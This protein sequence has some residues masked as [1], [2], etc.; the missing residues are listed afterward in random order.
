MHLHSLT[1]QAIGPFAGRHHIDF[2]ELGASGLFLLEGPTGAGKSTV[3]DAVVFALYGKVAS[4]AAS[5]D[6]LRSAYAA[7]E[8]ESF[9]D[10]I[11]ETGAGVFRVRRTPAFQ[12]PKKKGTGTTTQQAGVGLWRLPA[13]PDSLTGS[14]DDA[15]DGDLLS[16]RLDEAGAELQRI[17]GLDRQQFVQTVVLPQ[18]EFASFLRANPEDRR[19]LLQKVFG[20]EIYERAQSELA[21]MQRE[22][23]KSTEGARAGVRQG[24][25]LFCSSAQMRANDAETLRTA[26][27]PDLPDLTAERVAVL[28]ADVLKREAEESEANAQQVA[29]RDALDT[30]KTLAEK[31]TTRTAL[32]AERDTLAAQHESVAADRAHLDAATRAGV[33]VPA[34]DGAQKAQDDVATAHEGL[35]LARAD[36]LVADTDRDDADL[37]G[38][39]DEIADASTRLHHLIPVENLV[40]ERESELSDGRSALQTMDAEIVTLRADSAQRPELRAEH[41][42]AVGK[43]GALAGELGLRQE[44]V[45]AAQAVQAAAKAVDSVGAELADAHSAGEAAATAAVAANDDAHALRASRIAGIAGELAGAL[46]QGEGCP[47][48]GGSDHPEPAQLTDDHPGADAVEEAQSAASAAQDALTSA[49]ATVDRLAERLEGHRVAAGGATAN[50]AAEH[51]AAAVASVDEARAAVEERDDARS[52]LVAFDE[53]TAAVSKRLGD[54]DRESA[55]ERSR[56]EALSASINA[57]TATIRTAIDAATPLLVE[58][59]PSGE[60]EEPTLEPLVD[61]LRERRDSIDALISARSTLSAAEH[62][63][64]AREA[65]VA[66]IVEK[67]GFSAL[68]EALEAALS[69]NER[70]RLDRAVRDHEAASS[71]VDA[72]LVALADLSDGV[73]ADVAGARAVMDEAD[74]SST[75]A[76][77]RVG[78]ATRQAE[79]ART[80]AATLTSAL[81]ALTSADV[82]AEPVLRMAGLASGTSGDNSKSMS[83]ATFVLVR[84]FE[85]VVN[86]ANDRL[87]TMSDGR[88]ELVRSEEREAVRTRKM[89]LAMKVV[90]HWTEQSRDPRTLSGGETFYVS[91]CLALGMADV[92]TAEAGGVDLGTLFVDEGFGTLDPEALEKVLDVLG[93]LRDGGR[94]IGVVSHVDAMKQSIAERI[95]VR[96]RQDGSSTLSVRAGS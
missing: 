78:L 92:V 14:D 7:P 67:S 96:R 3:I 30:Q 80:A 27:T 81:S 57:D 6:R 60:P 69:D 63:A 62:A 35:E 21:E 86:A 83:L 11:L 34:A 44:R 36:A 93:K 94:T 49:R 39:R 9:V 29:A 70:A 4:D 58:P 77:T 61:R 82:A 71:R 75:T 38:L 10:L 87:V 41:E 76:A 65:E 2:A 24:V 22:A 5:E 55:A 28:D 47:V 90:D 56:L 88:Y 45:L 64:A 53:E 68:A 40:S 32:L 52:A 66:A 51:L 95:E 33:V 79:A 54:L 18:G 37:R 31:I 12:R 1:F 26:D 25:E 46:E 17:I 85:E 15:P 19:G 74:K 8:V 91:L 59:T 48:C 73:E 20:T 42:D 43:L 16:S 72:G 50:D 89:G 23:K 13:V 84:R